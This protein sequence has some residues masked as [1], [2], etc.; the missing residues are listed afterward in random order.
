M[1]DRS[2][3]LGVEEGGGRCSTAKAFLD[4][5]FQERGVGD[6]GLW[7]NLNDL[8]KNI[9]GMDEPKGGKGCAIDGVGR[10]IVRALDAVRQLVCGDGDKRQYTE[11][12]GLSDRDC[13]VELNEDLKMND[14]R[15]CRGVLRVVSDWINEHRVEVDLNFGVEVIESCRGFACV[16][17]AVDNG[18]G[19]MQDRAGHHCDDELEACV[20]EG[21]M[22]IVGNVLRQVHGASLVGKGGKELEKAVH[23]FIVEGVMDVV[24]KSMPILLA[25]AADALCQQAP[26]RILV[27]ACRKCVERCVYVEEWEIVE[28]VVK[29]VLMCAGALSSP[30]VLIKV[31]FNIYCDVFKR[32]VS[33]QWQQ[34]VHMHA[35]HSDIV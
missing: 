2:N 17:N 14:V 32:R 19:S 31:H 35:G 33:G 21:S 9:D 28:K 1:M 16:R 3:L 22:G 25:C 24:P 26:Q 6:S 34:W 5:C 30:S 29:Q 10:V 15:A 7:R 13:I 11:M 8:M 23:R 20:V 18:V 12:E 27:E 4:A